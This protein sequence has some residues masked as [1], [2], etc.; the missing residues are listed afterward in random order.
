[1]KINAN[2]RKYL[3]EHGI[4]QTFLAQKAGMK[5]NAVTSMLNNRRRITAEELSKI[6]NALGV[7]ANIFF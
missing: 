1:M 6:A 4:T 7:D 5:R 2:I 3:E